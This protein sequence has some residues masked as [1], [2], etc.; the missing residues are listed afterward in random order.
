LIRA[1]SEINADAG[2]RRSDSFYKDRLALPPVAAQN[3]G[4]ARK[5]LPALR[6][7]HRDRQK[8]ER[9]FQSFGCCVPEPEVGAMSIDHSIRGRSPWIEEARQMLA[10]AWPL[11]LSQLAQAAFFTT[12]V[13]LMG[14][15]GP[16][17]LAGISL[18]M[19]LMSPLLVGGFG[20]VMATA[21]MIS[22]A[23]GAGEIK[24]VRRTVR[25]G[26]WVAIALS[27]VIMPVL[28]GAEY[29]FPLLGQPP[30]AAALAALYLDFASL[31][32]LPALAFM[33]FRLFISS[34]GNTRAVLAIVTVAVIV[35][36]LL[37]Y[38][39]I[40]GQFGLP[41]L[42]IAGA[43]IATAIANWLMLALGAAYA[44]L[45]PKYRR[46]HVLARFLKPDWPRFGEILRIGLPI[47]LTQIS[48]VGLFGLAVFM[49][50]WI[51]AEAVAAHAIA[52]QCASLS[53]MVP[54]GLSQA[55]TIRV[56]L[57]RGARN[58]AGIGRAGWVSLALT[59]LFMSTTC[60]LFVF[61]PLQLAGIF[62]DAARPENA[63][64]IALAAS[65]LL[66]AGL[67]QFVDGTQVAMAAALRGL[68][69]TRV[70]MIVAM[71]GYW[72][73]GVSVAYLCGFVLGW[74][75]VGIWTGLAA[76]L[77]FVAVV[78]LI[79]WARRDR[80]GLAGF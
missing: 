9:A 48:E 54:L 23:L 79:R 17:A 41:A 55:T 80:L 65:Y 68:S 8:T 77:A 21:P 64:T 72:L 31:S 70:P 11:I 29:V 47:G 33:V 3:P 24:S 61:A 53:F 66:V 73:V 67:F 51:S 18:A 42:G 1:I 32:L 12:D 4:G 28:I 25:Q 5:W 57:A 19:A 22:Q 56:G 75:G 37:A 59:L 36:G 44:I 63:N 7:K 14:W 20:V 27:A 2:D 74:R 49:M 62:L 71:I 69:D 50:G 35:N 60:A 52:V 45:H 58:S 78:L 13:V 10:L 6:E 26:L 15:V 34:K 38:A 43:G 76:G 46:H 16:D 40:F 30:E 39:L